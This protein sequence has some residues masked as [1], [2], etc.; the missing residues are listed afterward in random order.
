M[1]NKTEIATFAAGCFWGVEK[2]FGALDG[3]V[4]TQVGYTGGHVKDPTYEQVCTGRTGHAEAIEIT[5]DP[6]RIRYED[7]IETFFRHHDPTTPNRQGNDVGTQYRSA[8]FYHSPGQKEA[9]ERALAALEDA[10]IFRGRVVT[11]LESASEF[12]RAEEYHQKYLKKNPFG[13]C[14]LQM[15]PAKVGEVLRAARARQ[16]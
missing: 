1:P 8:I 11:S 12:F 15:Q 9:A 13:Y 2:V 5:Y 14:S 4:S 16:N 6:S 10:K 3:V 7:L